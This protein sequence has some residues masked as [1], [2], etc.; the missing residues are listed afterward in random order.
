MKQTGLHRDPAD[1]AFLA[2]LIA[3]ARVALDAAPFAA[4][5]IAGHA[6]AYEDAIMDTR[7]WLEGGIASL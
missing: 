6:L 4:A 7:A 2:P 1:E 3:Q 5:E